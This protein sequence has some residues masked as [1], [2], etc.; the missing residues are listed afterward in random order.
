M[1]MPCCDPPLDPAISWP[2]PSQRSD[3][4]EPSVA[5]SQDGAL[6]YGRGI[7]IL[8]TSDGELAALV[9]SPFAA[10]SLSDPAGLV[11]VTTPDGAVP[12]AEVIDRLTSLPC[13]VIA[14]DRV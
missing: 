5:R 13:I 14:V 12:D 3:G 7:R 2:E 10:E 6:R 1:P 9:C 11:V 8:H 4:A